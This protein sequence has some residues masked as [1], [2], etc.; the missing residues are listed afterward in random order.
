M[1]GALIAT[2]VVGGLGL[3]FG[4]MLSFLSGKFKVETDP[5]VDEIA[6]ILPG[7]NCGGCGFPGCP[8]YAAAVVG[9]K[10]PVNL[11]VVGK[12][13]VADKIAG[14][15]GA[16]APADVEAKVVDVFCRGTSE[17]CGRKYAYEGVEDC[18]AA[19]M[20]AGGDKDCAFGCLGYGS[21]TRACPFDAIHMG[22]DGLPVVDREKCTGCANCV[23]V[24]PKKT[25][26]LVPVSKHVK[27]L[28][29]SHDKGATVRKLCK[30]GCIACNIC[31]RT[32]PVGAITMQ[33][34]LAVID[35]AKCDNC[36]KCVEKCPTKVINIVGDDATAVVNA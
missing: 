26:Q 6:G 24:C 33:D 32:C 25:L 28:C 4:A 23:A 19:F 31:V 12:K 20:L 16:G 3:I 13:P 30:N 18:Q 17:A 21:C 35:F 7:A 9:G 8:G 15:M 36:G 2:A 27:I 1:T 5:R 34:N 10:A 14:I 11:C 22:P 29:S